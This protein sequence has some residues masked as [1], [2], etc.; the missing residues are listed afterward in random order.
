MG[1]SHAHGHHRKF[2]DNGNAPSPDKTA[3][4][5]SP[6]QPV[7]P[8]IYQPEHPLIPNSSI[9]ASY[10]ATSLPYSHVDSALR[11]LAAQA[12]GFGRCAIGGLHGPIYYVTTLLGKFGLCFQMIVTGI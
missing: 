11:A 8:S 4:A 5:P 7:P 6:S 12:E 1:N 10:M 3:S 9:H 2:R